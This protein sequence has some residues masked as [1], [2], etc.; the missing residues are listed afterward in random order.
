[1]TKALD[2]AP[3][4]DMTQGFRW[5]Q[6]P[7]GPRRR[8]AADIMPPDLGAISAFTGKF[9]GVG[10]N[11]IF[12]PQN[13]ALSPTL[14]PNPPHGPD[15]NVL[16]L[17]LTE[18]TL[19]F[20]SPLG[21]VPN[22]GFTQ[23]DISLNGIP[24][25]QKI[26]DVTDPTSPVG[27]HFEPGVWLSV[28]AT[29]DPAE[30]ATVV[31]MA[32]IPHGT[33]IDA[34]GTAKP[35]VAGGPQIPSVDITPFTIGDPTS[36]LTGTFPSQIAADNATFRL[37]QDLSSFIAAGTITSD[38]LEN[39]NLILQNRV[40]S[41]T[42]ASTTTITVDTTRP[43]PNDPADPLFGGGTANIAFLL[44][45]SNA[46]NPNAN[47]VEMSATFWIETVVEHITVPPMGANQS[48]TVPGSAAAGEPIAA[49]S[50][51]S[52]TDITAPT[53]VRVTYTQ[54]QYSQTVLLNFNG[55]SWPHVSVATLIPNDPIPVTPGSPDLLTTYTVAAGDTLSS[56]SVHFYGDATHVKMLA[57]VNKI[58]NPNVISV[59]QVLIIPDLSH[60]Y[61]VAAGDTLSSI[62]V[63][64]YGDSHSC[65]DAGHGE[66]HC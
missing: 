59:G 61:T 55:L 28:P 37:P 3:A 27:I 46:T 9:S 47:A 15:D 1:M 65:E 10:F 60:T 34:E 22:R 23:A 8:V 29:T 51:T 43:S 11:T 56:I 4:I 57:T 33:T 19:E 7:S 42:I 44:G 17:N 49:F 24:Y 52:A 36:R 20:S 58:A 38:I 63:H 13:I 62:S 32:S 6:V 30:T 40:N 35:P 64:F 31:R 2:I 41:Q 25:V 18:E 66:Q 48:T 16:E 21:T 26:N 12:R 39:P 45:D 54:I 50:V 14:L 53:Q 5:G